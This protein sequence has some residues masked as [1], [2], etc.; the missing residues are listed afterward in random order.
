[1]ATDFGVSTGVSAWAISLYALMLAVA[2]AVYGR[3]SDL[4]GVRLPLLIGV[5][6]MT[7]GAL[8]GAL[9]PSFGILLAARIVQGAG[10]AAVPTLGVAIISARYSGSVRGMALGRVAGFAAAVSCIGPLAGGAIEGLL[11]WRAV[12]ALPMLG[13]LLL[14]LLWRSVPTEGSGARLDL[15]GAALVAGTAAGVV[16]FVQSPS[17]GLTVALVGAVLAVL[18]VPAVALWVRRRPNGFL[19]VA[20]IRNPAV[21][22]SALAAA[23]V[24]AAWFALLIAVPAVLVARG[25][26]P[27]QV[28]VALLPSAVAALAGP[29]FA[30]PLLTR[31]G[32]TRALGLA[33]SI[34]T[35]SLLVSALGAY[36]GSAWLLVAAVVGVTVAFGLGQPA[37]MEAV[38]S[39]VEEDVRGVALGI[40]TLFFLVGGSVGSAVVGGLGD[41]LGMP[42]ALLLLAALPVAGLVALVPQFGRD[43]V[44]TR[45]RLT[46]SPL[47][48]GGPPHGN[49]LIPL[50]H[51]PRRT[52]SPPRPTGNMEHEKDERTL[53]LSAAQVAGSAL[54][55][56]SGAILAS[57]AGV[58]GTVIGAAV[59]S[60]V[61]TVGAAIYTWSLRRT[62]VA[63]RKTAA[64]VRQAALVNGPLPRT[65]VQGPL[66]TMK[67]RAAAKSAERDPESTEPEDPDADED[68]WRRSIPWGKVLLASLA[69]TVVALAGITVVEALT[70]KPISNVTGGGDS[71]GTTVGNVTGRDSSQQDKGPSENDKTTP[72]RRAAGERGTQPGPG[73][74]TAG[75]RA[76]GQ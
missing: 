16:L 51:W 9:A 40:A 7:L 68:S 32:P 25:W 43:R 20:V 23:A 14:P 4:V 29:R 61:A 8:A 2:T 15:I 73:L 62:T 19:P 13:A 42:V 41:V 76:A 75:F 11:D 55:A 66:R 37:L 63:V 59:A 3:V 28:G 35:V 44:P 64:Q 67:E 10:A 49:E 46:S 1:M 56:V 22:R 18:G 36:A 45:G 71:Q 6:M 72:E 47:G 12:I 50:G 48:Q 34:A 5:S 17:T 65:V 70:G 53:G 69:I 21:V 24:P 33:A 26:E 57:T 58:T 39:A 27:W 74:R 60:V 54:A 30:G 31:I 38:G 52:K